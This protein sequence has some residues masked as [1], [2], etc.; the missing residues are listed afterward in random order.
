VAAAIIGAVLEIG[1]MILLG[2]L[3][4]WGLIVWFTHDREEPVAVLE[5]KRRRSG[6]E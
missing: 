6:S 5:S 4:V 1:L 2:V 3:A